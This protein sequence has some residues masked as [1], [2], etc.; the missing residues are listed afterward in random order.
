VAD[1]NPISHLVEAMRAQ[2]IDDLDLGAAMVGLGIA[3][4]L[5]ALAV[6]ASGVA[7]RRRLRRA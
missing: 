5:A 6:G 1:V 2:V 3:A 7:L 4:G